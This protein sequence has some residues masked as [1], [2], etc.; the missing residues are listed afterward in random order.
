M[1]FNIHH[2][3]F[4]LGFFIHLF[5]YHEFICLTYRHKKVEEDLTFFVEK[6]APVEIDKT[7][8][9]VRRRL[10]KVFEDFYIGQQKE[11]IR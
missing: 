9:D 2:G 11:K 5:T 8:G 7:S 3:F 4:F 6:I 10:K 1:N